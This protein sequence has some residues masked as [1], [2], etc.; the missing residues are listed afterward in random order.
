[1]TRMFKLMTMGALSAWL[2]TSTG[3][4][5]KVCKQDL[6][7][8]KKQSGDLEKECAGNLA[9][10]QELKTQ[11]ADSQSKLEALAKETEE[12]KAK[13]EQAPKGKSKATKAKGKKKRRH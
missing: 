3:C 12:L 6:Q 1:M 11:L 13:A 8:A 7:M 10:I 2:L 9:R 4:E 5:D